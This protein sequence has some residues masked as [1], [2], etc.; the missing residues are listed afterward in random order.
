MTSQ[1]NSN[2]LGSGKPKKNALSKN[3]SQKSLATD[4]KNSSLLSGRSENSNDSDI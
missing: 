3:Q 1:N 2:K 4:K